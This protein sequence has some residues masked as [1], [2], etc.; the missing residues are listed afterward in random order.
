MALQWV[1]QIKITKMSIILPI[2]ISRGTVHHSRPDRRSLRRRR[3][4]RL[5]RELD[6]ANVGLEPTHNRRQSRSHRRGK[7]SSE[8]ARRRNYFCRRRA[9][10]NRD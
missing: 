4:R 3:L 6:R 7:W 1:H 8:N 2:L 10:R 5:A 9:E